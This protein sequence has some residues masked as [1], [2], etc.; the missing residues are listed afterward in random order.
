MW[1]VHRTC[2]PL[3]KPLFLRIPISRVFPRDFARANVRARTTSPR[4]PFC[5]TTD[6]QCYSRP[7][8]KHRTTCRLMRAL[9]V[10]AS[11]IVSPL[12]YSVRESNS[13]IISTRL[14]YNCLDL[15][16]LRR[17]L[18]N[19]WLKRRCSDIMWTIHFFLSIPKYSVQRFMKSFD[20]H[21]GLFCPRFG[22]NRL[23][24]WDFR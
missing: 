9:R 16:D 15:R 19:W 14:E 5:D 10:F 4:R 23:H 1:W 21:R 18:I 24:L 6:H 7:G 13:G 11:M 8:K 20:S 3:R 2:A 17:S 22:Y 12:K